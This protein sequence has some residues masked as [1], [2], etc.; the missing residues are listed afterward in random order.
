MIIEKVLMVIF[1]K[2]LIKLSRKK[3]Y[4]TP[5]KPSLY[6]REGL[7]I[8]VCETGEIYNSFSEVAI[9]IGG[10]AGGVYNCLRGTGNRRKHKGYT[11]KFVKTK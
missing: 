11:F 4:D 1:S 6:S 7:S 9:A 2:G 3:R 8:M 5:G 10:N